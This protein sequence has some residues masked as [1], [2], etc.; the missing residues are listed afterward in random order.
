[1]SDLNASDFLIVGGGLAGSVVASRLAVSHPEATITVLEAGNDETS[2]PLTV[3]PLASFGAHFSPLDWA[4]LTVPQKHLDNVPRYAA[5]GK[6]L[7]GSSAT[8]YGTWTRGPKSDYDAWAELVGDKRWS[9]EGLLPYFKKTER[10]FGSSDKDQHGFDGPIVTASVSSSSG[11]RKYGL[12]EPVKEAWEAA[13][14]QMIG[15]ANA[16]YP[17]GFSE[18]VENWNHGKRQIA[19]A[20]YGLASKPN[21]RIVTGVLV[22]RLILE[23]SSGERK[24]VGVET[25][26]GK[27]YLANREVVITC[28]AYRTPQLLLLSGIGPKAEVS[29]HGIEPEVDLPVGLYFHDHLSLNQFWRLENPEQGMS[30]GT[31]LWSDHAYQ[32]GLP[33]D[34]VAY[35]PTST[36]LLEAAL[37][38]DKEDGLLPADEK[39]L[40][41][42][43]GIARDDR[44]HI[45]TLIVYAPAGAPIQGANVPLDG[46]HISTCV[47]SM[48]PTSRGSITLSSSNPGDP[49]VIDPNYY[50]T[51]S[52]RVMLRSGIQQAMKV[53]SSLKTK[54]GRT[55]VAGET[56]P[57]G[58]QALAPGASD[59]QIDERVRTSAQTFYHAG[60]SASMGH[61]VDAECRV[62]GVKGLRV[63]DASVIPAPISAHYQVPVYAIAEQVAEMIGKAH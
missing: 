38:Q 39:E 55:I 4:Y 29:R 44:A 26:D 10:Y 28:G 22:R 45:E 53:V 20:A 49:P 13:G 11:A 17:I 12:R 35:T 54:D 9:Y 46:S 27:A 48:N 7:G 16:G 32:L 31:P 51:E 50:A 34:W 58:R 33:C 14:V 2:N 18:L 5:A 37:K 63:A 36:E 61:V 25:A 56:P 15:D 60:G 47:L 24:A 23:R 52:D 6:A 30:V 43:R 40:G 3:S 42:V 19:S 21:V 62:K 57:P 1:M 59:G 8:N 41:W